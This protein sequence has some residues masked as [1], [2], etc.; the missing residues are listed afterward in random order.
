MWFLAV[1]A[2]GLTM[3]GCDKSNEPDNSPPSIPV[4]QF[5]TPAQPTTVDTCQ[6]PAWLYAQAVN[7]FALLPTYFSQLRP[8]QDG[9]A[10]VWQIAEGNASMVLRAEKTSS[11]DVTWALVLNGDDGE[12]TVYN[13][14]TA[15][16]GTT[17]ADGSSGT[18]TF[19]EENTTTVEGE[20]SWTKNSAGVLTGTLISYTSGVQDAKIVHVSNPNGSGE[21]T[22]YARSG[23]NWVQTFH[24]TW[25]PGAPAVCG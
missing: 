15:M 17:S 23:S 2:I 18:L 4:L 9:N 8:T 24:A 21:I 20:F 5:S 19:Y 16:R 3:A 13:N 1:L 12:G 14:W 10:W 25:A 22:V 7:E 6:Y 11:G